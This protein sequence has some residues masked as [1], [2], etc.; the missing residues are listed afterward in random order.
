M[1]CSA[2]ILNICV[3]DGLKPIL[4]IVSR[5]RDEIKYIG[6]LEGRRKR[7]AEISKLLQFKLNILILDVS[8]RWNT[9]YHMLFVFYN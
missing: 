6:S 8:T 2:H 1:R 7:W 4:S 3:Q 9:T 5:V